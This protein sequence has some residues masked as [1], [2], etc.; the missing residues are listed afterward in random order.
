MQERLIQLLALLPVHDR[1]GAAPL[2]PDH[3]D[4]HLC[5]ALCLQA[6]DEPVAVLDT[7][8]GQDWAEALVEQ[9]LLDEFMAWLEERWQALQEALDPQ[10][11]HQDPDALPLAEVLPW[12]I[13]RLGAGAPSGQMPAA[14]RA[15]AEGFLH[16][17]QAEAHPD[18]DP[19]LLGVIAAL[20]M[21]EGPELLGYLQEAYDRPQ[22]I[23]AAALIDDA[24]FA[25]QDLRQAPR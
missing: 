22:D 16:Q 23:G 13:D 14:A 6:A 9:E 5:A 19:E 4:G 18:A 11:L 2:S 1:S 12:A 15:W 7:C 20:T 3:L 17:C 21:D 8:W 10:Q 24:L 25:A